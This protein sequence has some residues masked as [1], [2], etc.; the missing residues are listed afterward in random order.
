MVL[1]AARERGLFAIGQG[2]DEMSV[3]YGSMGSCLVGGGT[4]S[5]G[6]QGRSPTAVAS[7]NTN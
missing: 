3:V 7:E 2:R 4:Q 1:F 6:S 5:G